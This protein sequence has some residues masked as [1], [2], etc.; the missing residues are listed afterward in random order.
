MRLPPALQFEITARDSTTRARCGI[1]RLPHDEMATP[2][3]MPVGT[4]GTVKAMTQ[5]ELE[6]LDFRM[7]LCNTYHLV[8]APG[9]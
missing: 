3:F 1:L 6:R 8:P 4:Q 9:T 7:I 5:E 2:V